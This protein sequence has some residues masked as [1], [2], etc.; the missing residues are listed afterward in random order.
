MCGNQRERPGARSEGCW[1]C[2]SVIHLRDDPVPC[3]GCCCGLLTQRKSRGSAL[4]SP[5]PAGTPGVDPARGSWS[6]ARGAPLRAGGRQRAAPRCPRLSRVGRPRPAPGQPAGPEPPTRAPVC[7]SFHYW[8]ASDF[9]PA[10]VGPARGELPCERRDWQAVLSRW[11][12]CARARV[13]EHSCVC[14][15]PWPESQPP[16]R[17]TDTRGQAPGRTRGPWLLLG[18]L[19]GAGFAREPLGSW[20]GTQESPTAP[21]PPLPLPGWHL[22]R[23][24]RACGHGGRRGP[25]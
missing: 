14:V 17:V 20:P 16:P 25:I 18:Q 8:A 6:Q 7:P 21:S 24:V 5:Q 4:P 13:Y 12:V 23:T 15:C 11:G 3:G 22:G 9:P 1:R 10:A 2:V 19:F